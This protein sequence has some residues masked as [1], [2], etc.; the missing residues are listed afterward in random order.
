MLVLDLIVKVE[1]L[2]SIKFSP[3][4]AHTKQMC[5]YEWFSDKTF[6]E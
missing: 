6:P 4:G 3:T 1:H 2:S 5:A